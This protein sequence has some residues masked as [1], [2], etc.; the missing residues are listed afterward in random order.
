MVLCFFS[1]RPG[2]PFFKQESWP[3][4]WALEI[5]NHV[6]GSQHGPIISV[7]AKQSKGSKQVCS[8]CWDGWPCGQAL[9]DGLSPVSG[10]TDLT[11]TLSAKWVRELCTVHTVK[12]PTVKQKQHKEL[13]GIANG[14]GR[15][16]IKPVDWPLSYDS[17]FSIMQKNP[18]VVW[19][20]WEQAQHGRALKKSTNRLSNLSA[21]NSLGVSWSFRK[22]S[23]YPQHLI[24]QKKK[25]TNGM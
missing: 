2:R 21:G 6:T 5:N 12:E 24:R 4:S 23:H 19:L 8:H 10:V 18:T 15:G 7:L 1:T 14:K 20:W 11:F 13:L 16:R 3:L 22:I 9:L 17:N 25:F